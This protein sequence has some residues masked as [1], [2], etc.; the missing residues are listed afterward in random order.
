[1][2][3]GSEGQRQSQGGQVAARYMGMFPNG[4]EGAVTGG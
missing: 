4:G 1:M 2:D 3:F